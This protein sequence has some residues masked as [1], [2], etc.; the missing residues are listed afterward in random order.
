L[1]VI[2]GMAPGAFPDLEVVSEL[3]RGAETIVYRVRRQGV[4]YA[5]KLL[6]RVDGDASR[7]LTAVRREAALL[8]CVGHPLLPRIFEVGQVAAGPYL[9]LEYIDGCPLSE[10]LR[11]GRLDEERAL[12]LAIDVVGPLAAA[13]RT[14]LVHRDVKPDN[15]IVGEDGTAR[16]IDFG[17]VARGGAQDDRVAGTLLYS[18]PEQTGMLKR[19]VDGRSD[20]YGLGVLLFESVTGQTPYRSADAGELIRLHATAP[21][22][23]TRALRPEL[24][25]M[26]AAIIETLMAKDPDDRYQS[27]ESLL[28]DLNR[29]RA[30]PRSVFEVG[31]QDRN[32]RPGGPNILVGRGK[33]VADLATRWLAARDGKGGAALVEGPAG[34][35][36]SRLVRELTTAAATDGDLVLYGKCLPDDPVP[37]APLRAAVERYVHGVD[38]LPP[39]ERE[40]AVLRLRRAVGRGGPLLRALSPMLAALVQAPDLGEQDRH[41]QFVNAVAAFLVDLAVEWDGA[42]LHI[43]DVQWLDGPTRRVLQQIAAQLPNAPLLVVA[44][45]RDDADNLPALARYEADLGSALDT[46]VRLGP[47]DSDAV[48]ELVSLHLGGVQA[49]SEM[50]RELVARVGGNPFTVVEYVRAVI[51]AGLITPSWQGWR[52][53]LA[54]LDRLELSD[55]ALDLVLQRIDGL[56]AESRRLL[57]AGAATGRRFRA[58]L[59]AAVCDVNAKQ[60]RNALAEAEA[61]RLVAVSGG[62]GYTFLHDRIREALLAEL[63]P[64]ALR[65]LHQRIAE[66]LEVIAPADPRYVYATAQHYALGEADRTPDKVYAS[67]LAAGRLA[68]SDHAPA[69]ALAFLEV[70]ARAA[71]DA[72]ITPEPEFHFAMGVSCFRTGR[73]AEALQLLDRALHGEPDRLRRAGVLA[74][75]A[76]VHLSSWDPGRA[77]DAARRG[78]AELGRPLPRG[79]LALLVTTLFAFLTGLAIGVTRIGFGRARGQTRQRLQLEALLYEVGGYALTMAMHFRMRGIM[80]FRSLYVINR[81]G[82]GSEYTRAM[83][84]FGLAA[85]IAKLHGLAAR[86]F[87]RAAAVAA[88][89]GD[90]VVVAHVEWERG[91][92]AFITAADGG[93]GWMRSLTEHERW[94]ELGDYLTALS[95]TC[96]HLVLVGRTREALAWYERGKAR[97]AG[98]A[99]AEGAALSAVAII[100][101]AQCGRPDEAKSA[102]EAMREVTNPDNRT[103]LTNLF[104]AR[105]VALVERGELG[106][107]FERLVA[108]W[109]QLG[110]G[111]RDMLPA[112]RVF[113]VF[114]ALGRLTQCHQA[115]REQRAAL[116]QTAERAV[117]EL[118]RGATNHPLRAYH[119][120]ARADLE[121]L[122]GRPEAALRDLVRAELEI[123]ELDAPLIAYE[124]ARVRARA[125]RALANPGQA[126]Q[127]ARYAMMLAVEHQWP[128]RAGWIRDEFGISETTPVQAT[129]GP[130]TTTGH[131]TSGHSTSGHRTTGRSGGVVTTTGDATG[132]IG[133]GTPGRVSGRGSGSASG[134]RP[135][136]AATPTGGAAR[137]G[138]RN[139]D[140]LATGLRRGDGDALNRRR[141]AALQQVSLA[142]ATVLEPRELAR[143]ALDETLRILGAERAYLFLVD[144]DLGQL[145]PNLGRD[146]EGNDIEELTAYSS[147]LVD[148]VR[149]TREA[150][151]VTGS[152][153]GLALGS[154]SAQTHGLRSIMIAPLLFNNRLR[155]VVYLDS[156]VAKGMFTTD[157]VD[158]LM[159]ITNHVALSLETVRAAQLAVAVQAASRQRDV[160][161][162]L[163]AAMAEQSATLDPDEVMDRLLRSLTRTLM[164]DAALLLSRDGDRYVVTASHGGAPVGTVLDAVPADLADIVDARVGA[165]APPVD[166]LVDGSV[167]GSIDSSLDGPASPAEPLG[168]LLGAPRSWL[169]IPVAE[170]GEPLGILLVG[171]RRDDAMQEA[172]V[173]VAAALAEQGMTAYENARLFS[174]VRQ[175][176]TIDGLTG[177]YNRNHF[178]VEAT[179]QFRVAQRYGRPV[180]AIMVD[181]DHFKRINDT[182]GHPVGDEVIRVVADRLRQAARDSD[183]LGRYGGE[184]FA[185]V[186]PETGGS[187]TKL[188]E[189][190]REI[191]SAEPVPTKVGPLPVTISVGMAYLDKAAPVHQG[192]QLGQLLA[193]ADA[194]LYEAKQAGRNRV[195]TAS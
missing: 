92:G 90:P 122:A 113:F 71:R 116:R 44:T 123:L 149:Y 112:Q 24:S 17:L 129:T 152:E 5:L 179:K 136:T 33:E 85:D 183:V 105:A 109:G 10:T 52:L 30:E 162:T 16:L 23:D 11:I 64:A 37:L 127:Q 22:P 190:L 151:V 175:L 54:G 42:I 48:A 174:Q 117:A 73:F 104:S 180:A 62:G 72:G 111:P 12:Q 184:E 160:A 28:A 144:D 89:T 21:I 40:L 118:G 34:V 93:E 65:R 124:A 167:D 165:A 195:A 178:F 182:H 99:K 36:K 27:G 67:G 26:F 173:E 2:S 68:L 131:R 25:P 32:L 97:L 141:L 120:V 189:R 94:L 181:I 159:A 13:H 128:H 192:L 63:D 100:L 143:V 15:I 186:T 158:I 39:G 125:L 145:V 171:S 47:L 170:R 4:D 121:V 98:G 169:A 107:P 20:L 82:P 139:S 168:G 106:E 134:G 101:A 135:V 77:F 164:G 163:R 66:V 140:E 53:D 156:R 133:G 137:T 56:G 126:T 138:A 61:R 60:S 38:D 80:S 146:G 78:L 45:G 96:V 87:D 79:K 57:A 70:A 154:R 8:G 193:R 59:V 31:T 176:A 14:G 50:T 161:E 81:L 76:T 191:V 157:D 115:T 188:A 91:A 150:V 74:Q 84:G 69:E 75:M 103:Q 58:D 29:L 1:T 130:A 132:D 172:Q 194:A 7:A 153:E 119:R 142:A 185:L 35:G 9:V 51:D 114:Q 155:G 102:I 49:S 83:A 110:L 43:D 88:E 187:A 55:D 147:T 166:G 6:T 177:L 3:G 95:G 41:E 86:T 19:P 108:E 18:A 148:R 46:R